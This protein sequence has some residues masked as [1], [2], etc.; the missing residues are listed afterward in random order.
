MTEPS[1]GE[2]LRVY[3]SVL[4]GHALPSGS[5]LLGA[6]VAALIAY[7]AWL[8]VKMGRPAATADA[9]AAAIGAV[10]LWCVSQM[11][12][13][14]LERTALVLLVVA[15]P[16]LAVALA[17][18]PSRSLRFGLLALIVASQ[19]AALVAR[20]ATRS[21]TAYPEDWRGAVSTLVAR[22]AGEPVLVLGGF[23]VSVLPHLAPDFARQASIRGVVR[24]GDRLSAKVV[25]RLPYAARF[26]AEELC[27]LTRGG[28][29]GVWS[30]GREDASGPELSIIQ[31]ALEAHGS[32]LEEALS[33]GL[34][35][36][37]RWSV[38]AGCQGSPE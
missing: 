27:A 37:R 13:V 17:Y 23:D 15:L 38:L 31:A 28:A 6:S 4:G 25:D 35:G 34:V 16:P 2:G 10:A 21:E 1:I 33:F 8:A 19:G 12:P 14:L 26:R 3:A 32:R 29:L 18:A 36:L 5:L 7:G 20:D 30:L 11:H 9:V 24:S 22:N